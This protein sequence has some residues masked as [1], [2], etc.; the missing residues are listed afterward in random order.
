VR[1]RAV[2]DAVVKR[3]IPSPCWESNPEVDPVKKKSVQYKQKWLNH[4]SRM[5]GIRYPKQLPDYQPIR[6]KTPAWQTLKRLLD[7]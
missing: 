7:G 5:E 6:R 3:K 4:I 1:P 2:L